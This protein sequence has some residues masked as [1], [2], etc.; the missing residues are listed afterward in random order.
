LHDL[1]TLL[2]CGTGPIKRSA[3]HFLHEDIRRPNAI[4][5]PFQ[6]VSVDPWCR[7]PGTGEEAQRGNLTQQ[8]L[9]LDRRRRQERI[10]KPDAGNPRHSVCELHV[11]MAVL[12]AAF[13]RYSLDA[14]IVGD[15]VGQCWN[16]TGDITAGR[17]SD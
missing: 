5:R 3:R 6:R 17:A 9:S 11:D 14:G 10:V 8:D 7:H 12:A 4:L 13:A 1:I 15:V 2:S 16:S